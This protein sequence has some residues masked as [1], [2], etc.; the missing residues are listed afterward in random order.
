LPFASARAILAAVG[1]ERSIMSSI[2]K[3]MQI[4]KMRAAYISAFE[5]LLTVRPD[6][7]LTQKAALDE[8]FVRRLFARIELYGMKDFD[9]SSIH[10]TITAAQLGIP[11]TQAGW[12]NFLNARQTGSLL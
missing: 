10:C 7:E 8:D 1:M 9:L 3:R 4:P 12:D 2:A 6:L 11:N 5:N